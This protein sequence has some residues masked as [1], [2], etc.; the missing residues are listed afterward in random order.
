MFC[1][2]CGTECSSK[3]CPNCGTQIPED[4][5]KPADEPIKA[6]TSSLYI[7]IKDPPKK[8]PTFFLCL[9]LGM[10][11]V[12]R[13]YAKKFISGFVYLAMTFLDPFFTLCGVFFD[14]FCIITNSFFIDH[15]KMVEQ[16]QTTEHKEKIDG[17]LIAFIVLALFAGLLS[18]QS[19]SRSFSFFSFVEYFSAFGVPTFGVITLAYYRKGKPYT[20]PL[21]LAIIC[22]LPL[23]SAALG[24]TTL[25]V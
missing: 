19:A 21:A 20:V 22:F 6:E 4:K 7:Q 8:W 24:F 25:S 9:F 17:W 13:F 5:L 3:F 14:L 15:Y 12:H 1:P 18:F 2:N 23:A 11:G 10:F 16:Y